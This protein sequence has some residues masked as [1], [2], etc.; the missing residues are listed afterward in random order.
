MLSSL[1]AAAVEDA[2]GPRWM[3]SPLLSSLFDSLCSDPLALYALVLIATLSL[4]LNG[5][6]LLQPQRTPIT[7]AADAVP[8][9]STIAAPSSG[10][11][12]ASRSSHYPASARMKMVLC[13]RNDLGMTKGKMCGRHKQRIIRTRSSY[14]R[15]GPSPRSA[16]L[17]RACLRCV[18]QC[19]H[20][21]VGVVD[22]MQRSSNAAWREALLQWERKGAM[23]IA[24]RVN[25][26]EELSTLEAQ[27]Q[28]LGLPHYLVVDAG[29]T[30]I[31]PNTETVLAIGPAPL[32]ALDQLT[33][34]LK[35]L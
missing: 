15:S 14:S 23:K 25:G 26:E 30:Q 1:L 9:T 2:A 8:T 17:S 24:L 29:H 11:S 22:A 16:V 6:L 13:V 21:A 34:H 3:S 31:A 12:S 10:A 28:S 7:A 20:A 5:F 33:G 35:L 18:A 27:A 4:G 19:G 32:D